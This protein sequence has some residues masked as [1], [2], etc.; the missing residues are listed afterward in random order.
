MR[1]DIPIGIGFVHNSI[2]YLSEQLHLVT[3]EKRDD[4]FIGVYPRLGKEACSPQ[5]D[6]SEMMRFHRASAD[7]GGVERRRP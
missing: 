3:L 4:F 7:E 5:M 6:P 1:D 2:Q